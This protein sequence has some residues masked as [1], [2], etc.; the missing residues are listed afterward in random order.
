MAGLQHLDDA[1]G[2]RI[3]RWRCRA[4]GIAVGRSPTACGQQVTENRSGLGLARAC[5]QHRLILFL[6]LCGL[7]LLTQ[8]LFGHDLGPLGR[9]LDHLL[10][11]LLHALDRLD[12]VRRA[13]LL[14]VEDTDDSEG[15]EPVDLLLA[16]ALNALE[17]LFHDVQALGELGRRENVD[18]PVGQPRR[19]PNVLTAFPDGQRQLVLVDHDRSPSQFEAQ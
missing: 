10:G 18:V 19:Q 8:L 1:A 15:R 4:L 14:D 16:D 5:R 12:K 2:L 3:G 17:A 6:A 9:G 7:L 11:L 13:D